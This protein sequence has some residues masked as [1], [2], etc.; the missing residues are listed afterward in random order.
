MPDNDTVAV[1]IP[2]YN[3][4]D[5]IRETLASLEQQSV[6]PDEIVVID[7]G[8][9]DATP[10]IVSRFQAQSRLPVQ[11]IQQENL[12]IAAARNTGVQQ[13]SSTFVAFLDSDDIY[14][15]A[16]IEKARAA[17]LQHPE[18]I[19]CFSDRDVVDGC[20]RLIR[21]DLDEPKFRA[22]EA[23]TL[24]DGVSILRKNPF[25]D[26]V[27]GNIIPIGNTMLRTDTF[28]RINGFDTDLR[29]VEDKSFF[30]QLAKLG[31]FGFIDEPLGT[32][33][34][35]ETNTSSASNAFKMNWYENLGLKR[36]EARSQEL[37]LSQAELSAIQQQLA[38][39]PSRLLYSAADSG[40]SS[41]PRLALG[42]LREGQIGLAPTVKNTMRFGWR[43]VNR[44]RLV[45]E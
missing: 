44:R 17:L 8:S 33:R 30:L 3:C 16:F 35:H 20:G 13:S 36:L 27:P 34:R 23:E 6:F 32:W 21:R 28:H 12:G 31:P 45:S 24:P 38:L 14:Y 40:N 7:D 18:L 4:A 19:L 25:R 2:A 42:C 11:V 22:L 15:P 39:M 9:T 29:A 5:Y 43:I 41:Y 37:E 1:I 26:L 10:G